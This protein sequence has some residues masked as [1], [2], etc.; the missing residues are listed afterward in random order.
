MFDTISAWM[1]GH[2]VA[3]NLGILIASLVI[4]I[5]A[6][7][8]AVLGISSYARK[9]GI[10]DYLIGFL[11][12]GIGTSLPEFVSAMMGG[13]VGQSGIVL[14]T[15][16]GSGIVTLTFVLG[17]MALAGKG[18]VFRARLLEKTK[19]LTLL[20]IS[21]P[22]ALVLDGRLSRIDGAI[23]IALFLAYTGLLWQREGTLGKLREVRIVRFWRDV[24]VF[25][26]SLAALLL[27]ARWLVF[28]SIR[29]AQEF[30][31]SPFLIAITVIAV[32]ASLPDLTVELRAIWRG[33]TAIGFGNVLGGVIAEMTLIIGLVALTIPIEIAPSTLA[34]AGAFFLGTVVLLLWWTRKGSLSWPQGAALIA[35]WLAFT[36]A[37][38]VIELV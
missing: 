7:D 5:W 15:L 11:V 3:A 21:A 26:G 24:A 30:E 28:S 13:L 29:L 33:H 22:L 2:P 20:L 12:L 25:L 38:I 27:G 14:G 23:L 36:L 32:G 8:L 10:S 35:L 37:Q 4:V 16:I 31:V 9:F 1:S 19:W 17:T 34:F 6:A 18:I